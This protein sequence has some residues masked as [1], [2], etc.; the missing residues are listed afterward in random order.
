[1]NESNVVE[2]DVSIVVVTWNAKDLLRNC[3]RS[4][5]QETEKP[6]EIIIV[7]NASDDGTVE[8]VETEF[9]DVVLIANDKN[10]GFAAA[11]NQGIR[12]SS[13]RY[14]LL[15]NPD[16]IVLDGAIDKM[17][18]WCDRHPEVGCAGCQVFE[19]ETIIQR[20]CF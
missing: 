19:T 17:I 13:G 8:M 7:D 18:D 16:T 14:L 10:L 15:L 2:P 11:N 20:T 1:M 12:A 6:H 3:I 4:I 5:I 9:S